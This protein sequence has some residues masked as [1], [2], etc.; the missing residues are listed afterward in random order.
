V[1]SATKPGT[2][3]LSPPSR[4]LAAATSGAAE[5]FARLGGDIDRIFGMA[6]LAL[7]DTASPV[8]ELSLARYCRLFEVAAVQTA[9]DNVGL[10]FGRRFQ[11]R[12]LGAIGYAALSSPT[13]LAAVRAMERYFAA[14]QSQTAFSLINDDGVLWL[15][16]R[17][18]DSRIQQ[19]RQDAELSL[20]MFCNVFRSALGEAWCPLEVRF[21]HDRP[22][23]H[24]EH[25]RHFG[26]PV[27]F[28]R[29]TNAFAFVQTDL[30]VAMPS[31]DPYLYAVIRP[32]LEQR[33]RSLRHA[34]DVVEIIRNQI[35]LNLGSAEPTLSEI[36]AILGMPD[37]LL[38]RLL[39]ER[40]VAFTDLVRAAREELAI[41][42]LRES[43]LSLTEIAFNLGYSEL[44]AFSRAFRNWTGMS[45]QHYRRGYRAL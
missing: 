11:P 30:E 2:T 45:P 12:Q 27:R 22:D 32:F 15:S 14:H 21:E 19:R 23:G 28:G 43:E 20:G 8:N 10:E 25:E 29:R 44:S 36:A 37:P 16:Y 6:G 18:L 35:K 42:Y 13:L 24:I 31:A 4:V 33:V 3:V 5:L 34:E 17:I 7:R 1:A 41:H 38:R 39:R 40:G 26:A 9:H